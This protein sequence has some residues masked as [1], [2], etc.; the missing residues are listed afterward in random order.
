MSSGSNL[1]NMACTLCLQVHSPFVFTFSFGIVLCEL[2]TNQVP[3]QQEKLATLEGACTLT[4][5]LLTTRSDKA[6]LPAEVYQHVVIDRK[7][8]TLPPK[9]DHPPGRRT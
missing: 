9:S 8:P 2:V 1:F 7:R 4:Y 3:Y 5:C 6:F